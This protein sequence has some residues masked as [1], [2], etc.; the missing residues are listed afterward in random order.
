MGDAKAA[1][2]KETLGKLNQLNIKQLVQGHPYLQ[3]IIGKLLRKKMIDLGLLDLIMCQD[4]SVNQ[5]IIITG[6]AWL[7]DDAILAVKS[8]DPKV[9]QLIVLVNW[10]IEYT[11]QPRKKE[12]LWP[13][14]WLMPELILFG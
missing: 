9:D 3:H 10:G 7:D 1:G 13:K 6:I 14:N 12:Q 5:K 4:P 2:L 11:H 8:C